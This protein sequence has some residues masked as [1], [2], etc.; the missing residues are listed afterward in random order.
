[1]TVMNTQAVADF[2]AGRTNDI[3]DAELIAWAQAHKPETTL[4]EFVA[5]LEAGEPIHFSEELRKLANSVI[6]RGSQP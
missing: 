6:A 5:Q 1:M 3:D 2:L 4:A